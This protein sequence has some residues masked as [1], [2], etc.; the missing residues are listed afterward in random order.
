MI[1]VVMSA[2]GDLWERVGRSCWTIGGGV[3][4]SGNPRFTGLSRDGH[5]APPHRAD[6]PTMGNGRADQLVLG[7]MTVVTLYFLALV[8]TGATGRGGDLGEIV[9]FGFGAAFGLEFLWTAWTRLWEPE[10]REPIG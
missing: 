2:R 3:Q 7:L 8:F 5:R 6:A 9:V 4:G 1:P 10:N